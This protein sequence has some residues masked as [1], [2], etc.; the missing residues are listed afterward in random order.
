MPI[1]RAIEG[2]SIADSM[3]QGYDGLSEKI[4]MNK[5]MIDVVSRASEE[6]RNG[7]VQINDCYH[8]T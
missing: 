8:Y 1:P 3:I 7:I 5:Q 6:Q 2:K 4:D